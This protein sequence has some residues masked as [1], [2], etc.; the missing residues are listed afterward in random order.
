MQQMQRLIDAYNKKLSTMKDGHGLEK[1]DDLEEVGDNT[2]SFKNTAK[3]TGSL[4]SAR[5]SIGS[6]L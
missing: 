2:M 3:E 5:K 4:H 6:H 1:L